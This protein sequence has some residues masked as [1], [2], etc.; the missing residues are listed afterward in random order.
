M[1]RHLLI[2]LLPM[3]AACAPTLRHPK[4]SEEAIKAEA[5]LQKRIA[6]ENELDRRARLFAVIYRLARAAAPDCTARP[7]LGLE[8]GGPGL[9]QKSYRQAA[10]E[11]GLKEGVKVLAVA[12]D[13][14][15]GHAGMQRGDSLLAINGQRV[16]SG[17]TAYRDATF[18]LAEAL[19]AGPAKLT[20]QRGGREMSL[21][22]SAEPGCPGALF[23]TREALP[24]PK[25]NGFAILMPVS[26]MRAARS[27]DEL[28]AITAFLLAYNVRGYASAGAETVLPERRDLALLVGEDETGVY[29]P[30]LPMGYM[31]VKEA[32]RYAIQLLRRAGYDPA[33][34]VL[35]WRR[36]LMATPALRD[37]IAWGREL[38]GVTR[39][40]R[41]QAWVDGK[42]EE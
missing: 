20:L 2:L 21:R 16:G 13:S 38:L 9:F 25:A 5:A 24:T 34:A 41:M 22:I 42:G 27:D 33:R 3:L 1:K 6:I 15:A 12:P 32:D 26:F 8:L 7:L 39:L 17:K 36:Y 19:Q 28:A 23:L 40:V 11:L 18:T 10:A 14:P 29:Q 30:P 31:G 37:D 35:F 4:V